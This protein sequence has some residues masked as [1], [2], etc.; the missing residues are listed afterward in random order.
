MS[1]HILTGSFNK[2]FVHS[3]FECLPRAQHL[4][5]SYGYTDEQNTVQALKE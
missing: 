1:C 2:F 4:I 5:I 3:F